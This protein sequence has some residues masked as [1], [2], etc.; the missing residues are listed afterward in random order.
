MSVRPPGPGRRVATG[1]IRVDAKRAIAKLREYQLA[2]RTTWILEAIRA[3]VCAGASEISLRGDSNDVWLDW[4]GEPFEVDGLATL[5][6]EL[7]SPQA[8]TGQERRLLAT[9]VNSALGL[10]PSYVDVIAI[11]ADGTANRARYTPKLFD[12]DE[13]DTA[14][15]LGVAASR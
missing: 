7:V 6:D 2:D 3:A 10:E 5:L 11:A 13:S 8:S 12:Q 9:A 1:H 15:D 4:S 14:L